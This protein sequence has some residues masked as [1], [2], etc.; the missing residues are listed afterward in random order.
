VTVTPLVAIVAMGCLLIFGLVVVLRARPEDLPNIFR[1]F[2]R[3][4]GR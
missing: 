4:F 2:T 1:S 3:R